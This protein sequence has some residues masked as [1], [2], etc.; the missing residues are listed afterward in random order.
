M[1]FQLIANLIRNTFKKV[2][3]IKN[4]TIP[5]IIQRDISQLEQTQISEFTYTCKSCHIRI[6]LFNFDQHH[7]FGIRQVDSEL[8]CNS[9]QKSYNTLRI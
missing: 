7:F 5:L 8:L 4:D 6:R 3:I 2:K 1:M 9:C